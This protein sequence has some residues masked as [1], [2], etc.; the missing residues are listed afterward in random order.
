M[1]KYIA[2]IS[3]RHKKEDTETARLL[4]KGI[5][6]A[7]LPKE[8][9]SDG[10]RR[11][12]RDTD[13][14]PTSSDLS[15]D[16][17]NALDDSDYLIAICSEDYV[18]SKW[19]LKEVDMY[20]AS[21]R[22]DR[23]LPVLLSGTPE[24]SIP[25]SIKDL[26]LASN[27]RDDLEKGGSLRKAV[28]HDLP[29]ILSK[30]LNTSEDIIRRSERRFRIQAALAV[31]SVIFL[32]LTGFG[33]YAIHTA[34][35]INDLNGQIVQATIEAQQ[36][37]ALALEE[38]N[39][40][41]LKKAQF[42]S[43]QAWVAIDE[44][45]FNDAIRLGLE[46]LP[47]DLN[48]DEP[49]SEEALAVL[50]TAL[51]MSIRLP[52]VKTTETPVS[53][54]IKKVWAWSN[55]DKSEPCAVIETDEGNFYYLY[56]KD[57]SLEPYEGVYNWISSYDYR[58]L[59]F[60]EA[61]N[62]GYTGLCM[63]YF[64][65]PELYC[66]YGNK[67]PMKCVSKNPDEEFVFSV[68]GEPF[69]A[70]HAEYIDTTIV[71]WHEFSNDG[72]PCAALFDMETS[73]AIAVLPVREPVSVTFDGSGD[74]S[75]I[76]IVDET[77]VLYVFGQEKGNLISSVDGEYSF[78]KYLY[79]KGPR[80]LAVREGGIGQFLDIATFEPIYEFYSASE[81][82]TISE[83]KNRN[84]ILAQHDDGISLYS[85]KSGDYLMDVVEDNGVVAA[86][87]EKEDGNRII[88]FFEDRLEVYQPGVNER[89]TN[90]S[91]IPLYDANVDTFGA[92]AL[93][94]SDGKYVYLKNGSILSKWD[95]MT[96]ELLWFDNTDNGYYFFGQWYEKSSLQVP[97]FWKS[98]YREN[99]IE[100][101]D[102]ET[103]EVVFSGEY[104][105]ILNGD[106]E[107]APIDSPDQRLALFLTKEY[108]HLAIMIDAATGDVLWEK[109]STGM[110][111]AENGMPV[112]SDD[113]GE[114]YC[115]Y[116]S[117]DMDYDEYV[118]NFDLYA[119]ESTSGK[120]KRYIHIE[121]PGSIYIVPGMDLAV[122]IREAENNSYDS[123]YEI[124]GIELSTFTL[125]YSKPFPY[126]GEPHLV[127]PCKG[128]MTLV[129]NES[130]NS[131]ETEMCCMFTCEGSF[132]EPVYSDSSEGRSMVIDAEDIFR[133]YGYEA[134]ISPGCIRRM[135]D[136]L[137]LL[138]NT[139][140]ALDGLVGNSMNFVAAPDGSSVCIYSTNMTEEVVPFII[141]SLSN[142]EL[143]AS[144]RERLGRIGG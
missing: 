66:F 20:I 120:E 143:V 30:M 115:V 3:Y 119:Y 37:Q 75:R 141:R 73:E 46:A 133:I 49:V 28:G 114:V 125:L 36:A 85:V 70:D 43:K 48:G 134:Y 126:I 111:R 99:G 130:V 29:G 27:L 61:K 131:N 74:G 109:D 24:T 108:S 53:V 132:G 91:A 95:A 83:C 13:E 96:G 121:R 144:A 39:A 63:K 77:G 34:N 51:A 9:K 118:E 92:M 6:N 102:A 2:F 100:K 8:L 93:Y 41:L 35:R 80:L 72:K 15:R 69:Y 42:L 122:C 52:Y 17:E 65:S 59:I 55:N 86:N 139:K 90:D 62:E 140:D 60:E 64:G 81:I 78:I 97:Y 67:L 106:I 142:E 129:W 11:V 124:I 54:N 10:R 1:S 26:P 22:K 103:G 56:Y 136:G 76:Y 57:G 135:N 84:M 16:I 87:W 105:S 50:R 101:I 38:R 123:G 44:G 23:I 107:T 58:N 33:I 21:G 18:K 12:F 14:L 68:N 71:A 40:A 31:F 110:I 104:L 117:A 113:S 98:I 4:R 138:G 7:H 127:Q 128:A 88:V 89:V 5:E 32:I 19:C 112:F 79:D 116:K 82:N 25:E 94:S 47:E 45:R 137:M